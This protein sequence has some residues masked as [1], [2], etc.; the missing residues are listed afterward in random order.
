[1]TSTESA[2]NRRFSNPSSRPGHGLSSAEGVASLQEFA[3]RMTR[4]AMETMPQAH[5]PEPTRRKS[6]AAPK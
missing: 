5:R 6:N 4:E 3:D 1:L 2:P